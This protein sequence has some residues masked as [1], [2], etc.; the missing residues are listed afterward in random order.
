MTGAGQSTRLMT[1]VESTH[2]VEHLPSCWALPHAT[3]FWDG[4]ETSTV[5]MAY[6]M[7][8]TA[9]KVSGPSADSS[10]HIGGW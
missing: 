3:T 9:Q 5:G 6:Y 8:G 10:Y 7:I 1:T 2:G 4:K